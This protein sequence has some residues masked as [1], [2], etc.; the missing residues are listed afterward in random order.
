MVDTVLETAYIHL[1]DG[2]VAR[3]VDV[4]DDI[5]VDL[6]AFGLVVGIEILDQRAPLPFTE[7]LDRFHVHSDVVETL[8]LIRPDV[9]SF[10]R[11]HTGHD[12]ASSARMAN[13]VQSV[14]S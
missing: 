6:D 4:N 14:V 2:Q 7:L 9:D 13:S 10:L 12:G 1:S 11:L 5:A 8:R 3:T